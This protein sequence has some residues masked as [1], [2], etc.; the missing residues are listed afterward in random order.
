MN[1]TIEILTL[2][3][4]PR[5]QRVDSAEL[6][7]LQASREV[8]A[9]TSYLVGSPESQSLVLVLT[10]REPTAREGSYRPVHAVTRVRATDTDS[11]SRRSSRRARQEHIEAALA[12][13]SEAERQAYESL[14]VWRNAEGI[15]AGV[16]AFEVCSNQS[17]IECVTR[18]PQTLT[19]LRAIKGFG[20]RRVKRFGAALLEQLRALGLIIEG[21]S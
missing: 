17:L 19:A 7:R 2:P 15:Q 14:R 10:V 3:Y 9:H 16:P 8:I 12:A 5:L 11:S 4:D 13:L 20:E 6:E 21:E 18:R 1:T